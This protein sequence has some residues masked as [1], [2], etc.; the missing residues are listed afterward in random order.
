M[1]IHLSWWVLPV[2]WFAISV[3]LVIV[4]NMLDPDSGDACNFMPLFIDIPVL[5]IGFFGAIGIVVG[6][7]L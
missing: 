1:D 2:A 7:F 5:A 3:L 4:R 6:H